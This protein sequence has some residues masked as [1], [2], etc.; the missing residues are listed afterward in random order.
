MTTP[1]VT[2]LY[3]ELYLPKELKGALSKCLGVEIPVE[4]K[5]VDINKITIQIENAFSG[6]IYLQE[7]FYK[8]N[9][10]KQM[11]EQ[12]KKSLESKQEET[13]HNYHFYN[14]NRKEITNNESD[15]IEEL[16]KEDDYPVLAISFKTGNMLM[17]LLE[18]YPYVDWNWN[19][20]SENQN[21]TME[22]IEKYPYNPWDWEWVS[23]NPILTME[24]IS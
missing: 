2:A 11:K 24:F 19:Y 21:L 22:I 1:I 10:I 7:K 4:V 8:N 13:L 3:K 18:K 6:L 5:K 14:E 9:T 12:V 23:A 17:S 15:T 20:I 16:F